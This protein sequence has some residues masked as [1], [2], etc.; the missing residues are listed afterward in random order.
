MVKIGMFSDTHSKH[1]QI[2]TETD[3]NNIKDL[4]ILLFAGDMTSRG[5]LLEVISFLDW[6]DN[7]ETTATKIIIAG[8]HDFYFEQHP[9]RAKELLSKY[10]SIHYLEESSITA[11]GLKIWGSPTNPIFFNWAFNDTDEVRKEKWLKIPK[12]TDIVLTHVPPYG[13]LDKVK[14]WDIRY[15]PEPNVGCKEL[16]FILKDIKPKLNCFGH[17]HE[18]RGIYVEDDITFIN[19][20]SLNENYQVNKNNLITIEL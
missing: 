3:L 11:H 16:F 7:L 4:D 17:I 20:S 19:A 6:L 2:F 1:K 9:A 14:N 5:S 13:I 18:G 10:K 8:N 12:D 15:N